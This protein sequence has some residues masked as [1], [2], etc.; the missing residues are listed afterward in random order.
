MTPKMKWVHKI[1]GLSM[2]HNDVMV[3]L[4]RTELEDIY[5]LIGEVRKA[6]DKSPRGAF[7]FVKMF[8]RGDVLRIKVS[9]IYTPNDSGIVIYDD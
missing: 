5:R 2:E 4:T 6:L 9:P 8:V 3:R 1:S 7:G